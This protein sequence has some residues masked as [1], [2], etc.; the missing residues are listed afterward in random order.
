MVARVAELWLVDHWGDYD[1][2]TVA[3]QVT[4][5]WANAINLKTER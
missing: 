2:D 5:L 4:L 1:L 3:D